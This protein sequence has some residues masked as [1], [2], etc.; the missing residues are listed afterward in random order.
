MKEKI[1]DKIRHLIDKRSL[2]LVL[3]GPPGAGK[4]SLQ[5][6]LVEILKKHDPKRKTVVVETGQMFRDWIKNG[7]HPWLSDIIK[8]ELA[9]GQLIKPIFAKFHW[10]SCL[11][12]EMTRGDEHLIFNGV[13][14]EKSEKN[15]LED[16]LKTI[17]RKPLHVHLSVTDETALKRMGLREQL[18]KEGR[19]DSKTL[20]AR[21]K[22]LSD[23]YEHTLP[24]IAKI[25]VSEKIKIVAEDEV[26]VVL[27]RM[28]N[29]MV[30]W[31]DR[32]LI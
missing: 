28:V 32:Q 25:P 13:P 23:Y 21:K 22:K 1:D 17:G 16:F 11:E 5:E 26:P 18:V 8:N 6:K 9:T 19:V 29:H 30:E 7:S 27:S 2:T 31:H 20:T 10:M 12:R 4:N 15:D 14:R 24:V 3:M